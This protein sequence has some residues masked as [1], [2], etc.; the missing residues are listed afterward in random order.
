MCALKHDAAFILKIHFLLTFYSRDNLDDFPSWNSVKLERPMS[1]VIQEF[2]ADFH[3]VL[4]TNRRW[5]EGREI[6]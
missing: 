4:N 3:L 2:I 6:E 5:G 1:Q